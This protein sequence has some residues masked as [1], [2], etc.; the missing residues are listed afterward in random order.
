MDVNSCLRLR[1]GTAWLALA[2]LTLGTGRVGAEDHGEWE[3]EA[4]ADLFY[5]SPVDSEGYPTHVVVRVVDDLT[6]AALPGASVALHSQ[7]EYPITGLVAA[8]RTGV[9]DEDGWVRIR[10]SDLGWE[11]TWTLAYWLYVEAAGYAGAACAPG[12]GA[13]GREI[14]LQRAQHAFVQVRDALDRPVPGALIGVRSSQTCG[15]MNDQRIAVAGLDGKAVIPG[16]CAEADD[17]INPGWECCAVADGIEMTY[18]DLVVSRRPGG[19]QILRHAPS[20]PIV[21]IVRDA[22]GRPLAGAH[23]GGG[24]L[25]RGPWA[26]TDAAGRF[27][28]V[29]ADPSARVRVVQ[30]YPGMYAEDSPPFPSFVPPPRGV[31]RVFRMPAPGEPPLEEEMV[32]VRI[33]VRDAQSGEAIENAGLVAWREGD[34]WTVRATDEIHALPRGSFTV[35]AGGG[36]SSYAS[37]SARFDVTEEEPPPLRLEVTRHPAI[38]VHLE[39]DLEDVS[40]SLVSSVDIRSGEGLVQEIKSGRVC[41]PP[42]MACAFRVEFT[43]QG[44]HHVEFI[45]IP[46]KRRADLPPLRIHA[47]R[48]AIVRAQLAGPDG[49]IVPGWLLPNARGVLDTSWQDW[50][51]ETPAHAKPTVSLYKEGAVELLAVPEGRTL[52]PRIITAHVRPGSRGGEPLDLGVV[53]LEARGDRRLVILGADG[54]PAGVEALRVVRDGAQR[55]LYTTENDVYDPLLL[56]FGPGAEVIA[57]ACWSEDEQRPRTLRKRLEG[58]GPWT[59]RGDEQVTSLAVDV[60]D[61]EGNALPDAILVID[62]KAYAETGYAAED[63]ARRHAPVRGLAPGP[64]RVVVTARGHAARVYRVVLK[65]GESRTM[66]V[67]L[68]AN[69]PER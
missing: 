69:Q 40:I 59:L 16:L 2:L 43:T 63:A 49:E 50:E 28:L 31:R 44:H 5:V 30:E 37:T 45:P 22:A 38:R 41:I 48:A 53:R 6:G 4:D 55:H 23:V 11:P 51:A 67:R 25:H 42:E 7:V 17:D 20:R 33:D 34:G 8:D 52:T 57:T 36:L 60:M 24:G 58:Q 3:R 19:P 29:G 13:E 39:D 26:E 61:E 15:H 66:K 62:G 12:G 47:S 56:P 32:Q 10:A 18:H 54:E 14:R 1:S 65:Q 27:R 9:A 68:R 64:H 21:G 46:V 35:R